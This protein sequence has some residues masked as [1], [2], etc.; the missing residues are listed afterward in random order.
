MPTYTFKNKVTSEVFDVSMKISEYDDYVKNNPDIERY[1]ES[2][3]CLGDPAI[4]GY[5]KP[6]SDFQK[7][8]IGS[9]QQRNPGASRSKK[10][11]VPKEW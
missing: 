1:H 4:L 3:P 5:Q 2:V 9:I 8:I 10:F 6:P 7:H 11:N